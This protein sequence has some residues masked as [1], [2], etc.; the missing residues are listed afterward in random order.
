MKNFVQLYHACTKIMLR[1][2]EKK[3][4]RKI[5]LVSIPRAELTLLCMQC[6]LG[7]NIAGNSEWPPDWKSSVA[8]D[9]LVQKHTMPCT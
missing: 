1:T 3:E 4:K 2:D 9:V 7:W 8:V 6:F 5:F